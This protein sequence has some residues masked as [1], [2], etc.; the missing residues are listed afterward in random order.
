MTTNKLL[1]QTIHVPQNNMIES[2][3]IEAIQAKGMD[4]KYILRDMVDRDSL[5]G[6]AMK[7]KFVDW[8]EIEMYPEDLANHDGASDMMSKFG[9]EFSDTATFKVSSK[10][11][12]DELVD[13]HGIDRPREGDLIYL[14]LSDAIFEIKKVLMDENFRQLGTNYTYRLKCNLFQYSHEKLPETGDM[15]SFSDLTAV[16]NSDALMRTLG[17]SGNKFIDENKIIKE[18]ATDDVFDPL[19]P[20]KERN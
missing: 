19:D 13:R 2:L 1:N 6:E 7:S 20:L 9:M 16:D 14:P 4:V 5:F 11:F 8:V 18:E 15:E 17:I 12:K 10:R 3:I